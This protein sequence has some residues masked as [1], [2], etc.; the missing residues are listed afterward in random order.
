LIAGSYK[1]LVVES[2]SGYYQISWQATPNCQLS[3]L[4]TYE[5]EAPTVV[6]FP[7]MAFAI[8][9]HGLTHTS[10]AGMNDAPCNVSCGQTYTPALQNF[11]VSDA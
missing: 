1:K 6:L 5:M 11:L 7:V 3:K 10:S 2:F 8:V 9:E 4:P